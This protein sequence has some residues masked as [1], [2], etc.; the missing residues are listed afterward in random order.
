MGL[1]SHRTIVEFNYEGHNFKMIDEFNKGIATYIDGMEIGRDKRFLSIPF[2]PIRREYGFRNKTGRL[3]NVLIEDPNVPLGKLKIY[4]NGTL[5][6][7]V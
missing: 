7:L 3:I 4:F 2:V 6:K 1:T 5:V